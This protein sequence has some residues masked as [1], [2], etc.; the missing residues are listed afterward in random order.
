MT[1]GRDASTPPIML[2][3]RTAQDPRRWSWS[4]TIWNSSGALNSPVTVLH[5]GSVLAEGSLDT[6]LQEQ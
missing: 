5:E 6:C 1:A 2:R 4:S 3:Q